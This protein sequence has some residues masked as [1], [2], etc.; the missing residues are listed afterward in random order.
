MDIF[1]AS[2]AHHIMA[3]AHFPD[4]LSCA[5]AWD[6]LRDTMTLIF[7]RHFME[8]EEPIALLVVP[9][10][11]GALLRLLNTNPSTGTSFSFILSI[12][13]LIVSVR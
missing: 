12:Q 4:P 9:G 3:T 2:F 6:L 8:M 5:E 7:R 11:C 10:V 13:F 1:S